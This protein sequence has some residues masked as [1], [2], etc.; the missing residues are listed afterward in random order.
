VSEPLGTVNEPA[1]RAVVVGGSLAGVTAVDALR[2]RGFDGHITLIGDE[3]YGAYSRPPLSK[4][5]L[6]GLEPADSV[7]LPPPPAGVDVRVRTR[8]AGLD[9]Q[10]RVVRL[11]D[12]EEVPYDR[13]VI[14]TGA[15]ARTLGGPAPATVLR[16]LDDALAL[17]DRLRDATDV[18]ILGGGFLGMEIASTAV[19]LGLSVTVVD[20]RLPLV[21]VLGPWLAGIFT[22]AARRAGVRIVVSPGGARPLEAGTVELRDGTRLSADVVVTAVGD[23]PNVEWLAGSGL[24]LRGGVVVDARCRV[25]PEIVAAG[26]VA[27]FPDGGRLRRMPHWDAAMAQAKAAADA[28]LLGEAAAAYRPEPYYWT[29]AFGLAVKIA[30]PL[31]VEGP[32]TSVEGS[33]EQG[34]ALLRWDR[35]PQAT[36]VAVNY[37][38]SVAK[39]RR[40]TARAATA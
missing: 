2:C 22:H 31:P 38:L 16:D 8:A 39:L 7:M 28:L 14:A 19:R 25:S 35:D 9:L 11:A 33:L 27:A 36:A 4:G 26:D 32:P 12:G 23:R 10:R 13:L 17:R 5:V 6:A 29:D 3:P 40:L 18:L 34:S 30:G 37:H 1:S 21:G 20:L 15:R 24:A